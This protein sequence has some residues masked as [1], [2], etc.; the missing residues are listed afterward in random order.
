MPFRSESSRLS[1][2]WWQRD[3]W[4]D[5]GR[6][7]GVGVATIGFHRDHTA[8]VSSDLALGVADT[9]DLQHDTRRQDFA[10]SAGLV[11]DGIALGLPFDAEARIAHDVATTGTAQ[12]SR[13]GANASIAL[14]WERALAAE[15]GLFTTPTLHDLVGIQA[16]DT[17]GGR[18]IATVSASFGRTTARVGGGLRIE[19]RN[20][21]ASLARSLQSW[22]T[23]KVAYFYSNQIESRIASPQNSERSRVEMSLV[24]VLP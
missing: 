1:A 2:A 17:L 4:I 3:A 5:R 7:L 15:G 10:I 24:A 14:T 18:T 9:R 8:E 20:V 16:Q 22:L 23:A 12:V 21:S 19:N 11:L 13:S 6:A